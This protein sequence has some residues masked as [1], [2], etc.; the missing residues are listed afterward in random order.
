MT[1]QLRS[2]EF[3]EGIKGMKDCIVNGLKANG[4]GVRNRKWNLGLH[5]RIWY[6]HLVLDTA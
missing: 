1:L 5:L 6:R 3:Q 2:G 4:I